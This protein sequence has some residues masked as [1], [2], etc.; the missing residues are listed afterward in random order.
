MKPGSGAPS[1]SPTQEAG[2]KH[3]GNLLQIFQVINMELYWKWGSYDLNSVHVGC[4]YHRRSCTPTLSPLPEHILIL[5]CLPYQ[6]SA[7]HLS[8]CMVVI[9]W[10]HTLCSRFNMASIPFR[11]FTK[12]DTLILIL[13]QRTMRIAD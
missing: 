7:Q 2:T 1:N 10:A 12:S 5:S 9:H 3:L 6:F 4:R 13:Q 8:Y 11:H